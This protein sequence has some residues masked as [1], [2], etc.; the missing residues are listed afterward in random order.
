M[1]LE[2]HQ[3]D[4]SEYDVAVGAIVVSVDNSRIHL[5]DDDKHV[6]RNSAIVAVASVISATEV[7]L[8][9]WFMLLVTGQF[10]C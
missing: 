2:L 10:V 4:R 7:I 3:A 9:F 5:L 1:W 6:R 8:L